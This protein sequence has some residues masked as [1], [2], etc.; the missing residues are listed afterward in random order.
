MKPQ[1]S[2]DNSSQANPQRPLCKY[3]SISVAVVGVIVTVVFAV[4]VLF[5]SLYGT[6]Y[7]R[8]SR[9]VYATEEQTVIVAQI[10][11][12]LKLSDSSI[13][14]CPSPDDFPHTNQLYIIPTHQLQPERR[15]VSKNFPDV[16]NQ[17]NPYCLLNFLDD[18]LY[19]LKDSMIDFRI[20]LTADTDPVRPGTLLI[21]DSNAAYSNF[22][23]NKNCRSRE[24]VVSTHNLNIGSYGQ[25]LCTNIT[26]TSEANGYHYIVADTPGNI[27]FYYRYSYFQYY[28]N[29]DDFSQPPSCVFS[30]DSDNQCNL[31]GISKSP[32]YLVVFVEKS[33]FDNSPSTH[34]CLTSSGW[35]IRTM[36]LVLLF[37]LGCVCVFGLS[38][39][40]ICFLC[41]RHCCNH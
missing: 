13:H 31:G 30:H 11:D 40:C 38:V 32:V 9:K 35:S 15:H 26:Y 25:Y 36:L 23:S 21:F 2:P 29:P 1:S 10:S 7:L 34:V 28:L 19:L 14:E 16:Q 12:P 17:T 37:G 22:V 39:F 8:S 4:A 33:E 41:I 24:G 6:P 27:K 18:H 5:F 20:C 3:L